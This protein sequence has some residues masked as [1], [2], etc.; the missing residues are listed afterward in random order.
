METSASQFAKQRLLT[1]RLGFG[2]SFGVLVLLV[3]AL[4]GD[5]RQV[6]RQVLDFRWSLFPLVLGLTLFNYTLRFIKWHYYLRLIGA[7]SITYG[8]SVRLFIAGFPL[9]VTPG[10]LGE[11]LKGVWLNQMSGIAVALGVSVVVAE[12]VSDGLAVSLLALSG[13]VAYPQYWLAFAAILTVLLGV[14]T[15]SQMRPLALW[16]LGIGERLP[17]IKRFI[18]GFRLFYEG[19]AA[20]FRPGA[21]LL[22]VGLGAISWLGEG[23]GF[24]VI[25]LGLGLPAGWH[26]LSI[27]VFTLS[28]S[29]VIGAASTLPAGLGASEASIAA[30]LGVLLGLTADVSAAATLLIRLATLWFGVALGLIVWAFSREM[31][32][33]NAAR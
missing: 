26:T 1:R 27:A 16:L 8:E 2:I 5:L 11:A 31:L 7:R 30:M 21:L 29:I 22:A 14:V 19:S 15:I 17:L 4:L 23:L 25:L 28:F 32:G 9:A 3:V 10:K 33:F 12:R 6:S 20:L 13:V 24:Y 18:H